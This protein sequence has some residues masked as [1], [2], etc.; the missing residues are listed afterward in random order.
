MDSV[1]V[2]AR[3]SSCQLG[4]PM[5]L[6]ALLRNLALKERNLHMVLWLKLL[7]CNDMCNWQRQ[8]K[9]YKMWLFQRMAWLLWQVYG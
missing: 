6:K 1:R 4:R 5:Q 8:L 7:S 9:A 2:M 3:V